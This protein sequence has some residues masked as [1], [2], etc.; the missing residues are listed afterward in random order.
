MDVSPLVHPCERKMIPPMD[1]VFDYVHPFT[2]N[3][4]RPQALQENQHNESLIAEIWDQERVSRG[5]SRDPTILTFSKRLGLRHTS[6]LQK[7][8]NWRGSSTISLVT[9]TSS[10]SITFPISLLTIESNKTLFSGN[11]HNGFQP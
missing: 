2:A 6:F 4:L 10:R 5:C 8:F 3:L 9:Q 7:E 11:Y 1:H